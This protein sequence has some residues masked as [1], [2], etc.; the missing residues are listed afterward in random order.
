MKPGDAIEDPVLEQAGLTA[1]IKAPGENDDPAKMVRLD[2]KGPVL[3]VTGADIV[4]ASGKSLV[5]SSG[6]GGSGDQRTYTL[7]SFS[8]YPAD[9]KLV[10]TVLTDQTEQVL[11]F[12]F[13][14]LPLPKQDA[15]TE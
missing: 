7:G 8:D 4:D 6:W 2:V 14:S 12:R 3:A 11:P 13:E 1:E 9:A 15:A 10:I 5:N